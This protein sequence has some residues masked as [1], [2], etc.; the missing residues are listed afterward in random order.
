MTYEDL[1]S[2]CQWLEAENERLKDKLELAEAV[3]RSCTED[4]VEGK[5]Y[6]RATLEAWRKGR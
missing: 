1:E 4:E 5:D 2:R 6:D 3:C